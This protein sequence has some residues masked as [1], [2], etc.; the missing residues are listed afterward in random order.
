MM[1]YVENGTLRITELLATST[2]QAVKL[3][4]AIRERTGCEQA[5]I[6]L[7]P[8]SNLFLGEGQTIDWCAVNGI[9]DEVYA[10]LII[11]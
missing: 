1:P 7:S 9:S 11:E 10:N 5:I 2:L 4:Q 6:Y 8:Q 3:L